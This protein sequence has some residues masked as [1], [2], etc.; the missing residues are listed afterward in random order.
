MDLV[1]RSQS[2]GTADCRFIF[3]GEKSW[4]GTLLDG[5]IQARIIDGEAEDSSED[6]L[7]DTSLNMNFCLELKTPTKKT[8]LHKIRLG[9]SL[10]MKSSEELFTSQNT[11]VKS[12]TMQ[13]Q[14]ESKTSCLLLLMSIQ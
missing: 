2:Y 12:Y 11:S 10:E 13:L 3:N 7:S 4:F 9:V 14:L 1:T 8:S 6:G 5:W